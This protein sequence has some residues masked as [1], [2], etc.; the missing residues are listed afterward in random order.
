LYERWTSYSKI[1]LTDANYFAKKI[2]KT[3]TPNRT[4]LRSKKSKIIVSVIVNLG[5][6][7]KL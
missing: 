3:K 5:V 7:I 1:Y 2:M 4:R 6:V